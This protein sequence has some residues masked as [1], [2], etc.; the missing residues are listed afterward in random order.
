MPPIPPPLPPISLQPLPDYPT[1]QAFQGT[2]S[3]STS[4]VFT[5][6]VGYMCRVIV[7]FNNP[8]AYDVTMNITRV[9]DT[10]PPST[11]QLYSLTLDP[12]DTVEDSGYLLYPGDSIDISTTTAGTNY[13]MNVNCTKY[14]RTR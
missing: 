9:T 5:S 4:T 10:N 8:L 13:F 6:P 14:Y 7:R 11:L 12:G 3:T 1:D 2:L